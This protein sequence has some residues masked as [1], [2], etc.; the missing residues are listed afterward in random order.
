MAA[1]SPSNLIGF[2]CTHVGAVV[3]ACEDAVGCEKVQI[4]SERELPANRRCYVAVGV[5]VVD[6]ARVAALSRCRGTLVVVDAV[7]AL[8]RVRGI[9]VIDSDDD[10][11]SIKSPKMHV[12]RRVLGSKPSLID[13][14]VGADA[15][16]DELTEEV[17]T[18]GVLDSVMSAAKTLGLT[19]RAQL[20][21]S[22]ARF[23]AGEINLDTLLRR[24]VRGRSVP[25]HVSE[26][27]RAA[28]ESNVSARLS[29]AV[30]EALA[31]ADVATTA[32]LNRVD[33]FEVRY[34]L[35]N[36]KSFANSSG[37]KAGGG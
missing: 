21:A 34:L 22:V 9:R 13:V 30:R 26:S 3:A 12:L 6:P 29:V 36:L 1:K 15:T 7:P 37:K 14:S 4:I 16:L 24:T 20:T 10:V 35:S 33:P 5:S 32:A 17:R 25:A 23:F 31:G 2:S 18:R 11:W 28:M 8:R 19:E 27:L